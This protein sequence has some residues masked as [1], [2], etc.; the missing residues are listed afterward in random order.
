[1]G[2]DAIQC[3]LTFQD[4]GKDLSEAYIHGFGATGFMACP[5]IGDEHI[6]EQWEVYAN[7][8]NATLPLRNGTTLSCLYFEVIG[9]K[10]NLGNTTAAFG[11]L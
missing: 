5:M 6:P 11:Y 2:P 4:Y 8:P 7:I 1:M 9:I 3:P 10:Y